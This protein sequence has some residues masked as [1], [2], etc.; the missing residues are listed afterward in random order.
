MFAGLWFLFI[1][2]IFS[3]SLIWVLDNNG[4]V[5]ISWLEY[6]IQTDILTALLVSVFFALL[7]FAISHLLARILAVR[8]PKLLKVFF[9]KQYT[10][11]LEKTIAKQEKAFAILSKILIAL[12]S[13]D[14][15][16]AEKLRPRLTR[17][18]KDSS[19]D[20]FLQGKILFNKNKFAKSSEF[21]SKIDED[22]NSRILVLKSKFRIAQKRGDKISAIAYGEQILST[23]VPNL[24]IAKS[25]FILYK[26]SG[27]FSAAK[28]LV[29]KY[30]EANFKDELQK[31]DVAVIN[32]ALAFQAYKNGKFLKAVRFCKIALKSEDGFLPAL[33]ILLRAWLKLGLNFKVRSKIRSLWK[34]NPHLIFA[35]IF[36]LSNRKSSSERRIKSIEKLAQINPESYLSKLAIGVVGFRVSSYKMAKEFLQLSLVQQQNYRAYKILAF[37]E[38]N[39]GNIGNYKRNLKKAEMLDKADHY[40]CIS[41]KAVS[42]KWSGNCPSCQGYDSLE[43]NL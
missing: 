43:W 22:K 10:K 27:S 17:I 5:V 41:C 26:K 3:F 28:K 34:Y 42:S 12:D 6:E 33:E 14:Q 16:L 2:F 37:V 8:F 20:D 13:G 25:L 19:L 7:I 1:A 30:G 18:I 39:L 11:K 15:E 23:K 35:E 21:F 4:L 38:K 29:K 24:E 36:D 31:R 40:G 9:K 32:C